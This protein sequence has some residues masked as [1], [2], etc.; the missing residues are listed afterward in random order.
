MTIGCAV[1]AAALE[2]SAAEI[3]AVKERTEDCCDND[4]ESVVA[5]ER[6]ADVEVVVVVVVD[7]M[8]AVEAGERAMSS[9]G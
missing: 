4:L 6:C 2:P 1:G 3:E 7:E 8:R 9:S 5:L